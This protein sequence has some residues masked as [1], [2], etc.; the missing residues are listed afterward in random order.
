MK[1]NLMIS[2]IIRP[3][4]TCNGPKCGFIEKMCTNLRNENIMPAAKT[5]SDNNI[6]SY[7]SHSSRGYHGSRPYD[8]SLCAHT[9]INTNTYNQ[10]SRRLTSVKSGG[11]QSIQFY[12]HRVQKIG[13]FSL[14]CTTYQDVMRNPIH[15]T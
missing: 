11:F 12:T 8:S 7:G 9:H 2:I 15:V 13:K 1:K 10:C 4:D 6:G 3:S 5:P 14:T